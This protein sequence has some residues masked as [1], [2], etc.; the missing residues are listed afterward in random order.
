M[1]IQTQTIIEPYKEKFKRR[2]QNDFKNTLSR[3]NR[4]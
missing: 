4:G 3:F 1:T 2:N